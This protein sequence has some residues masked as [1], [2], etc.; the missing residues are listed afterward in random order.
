MF[1]KKKAS[2]FSR[3]IKIAGEAVAGKNFFT[4]LGIN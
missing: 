1:L 3:N 2:A 4:R